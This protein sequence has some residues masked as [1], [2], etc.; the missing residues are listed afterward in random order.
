MV[1]I[2]TG[3]AGTVRP[4]FVQLNRLIGFFNGTDEPVIYDG[5]ATRQMGIT[6]PT[7]APSLSQTT[8]GS[9]TVLGS[10][11]FAYTYYNSQT[12]AESSPSPLA[13]IVLTGANNKVNLTVTAGSSGTADTIRI[14]RTTAN[15]NELFLEATE[16]I[17]ATTHASIIADAGLSSIGLEYDNSRITDFVPTLNSVE[18]QY[19]AVAQNRVFLKTDRNT[20][21]HSKIGQSGPMFESF[22]ASAV[23][24]C[25]G[26][27]GDRD[28]VIGQGVAGDTPIVVKER[29]IGRLDAVGVNPELSPFDQVRYQYVEIS[30]T[31]GGVSHWAGCS[32]YDE[33]VFLGRDNVYATNG[34]SIRPIGDRVSCLSSCLAGFCRH[35]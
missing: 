16:T 32:V 15:G 17:A 22:E 25:K 13:T 7:A 1:D 29:S 10:Y 2:L 33:Y 4:S 6:A 20:I 19:P 8:G 35:R 31:V 34:Q 5:A 3:L 12:G 30:S 23:A 9:L 24:Y 18:A 26:K 14:Y 11:V 21:R 27:F 28:D